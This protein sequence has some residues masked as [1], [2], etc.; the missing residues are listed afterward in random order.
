MTKFLMS[1]IHTFGLQKWVVNTPLHDG[2]S[3]L[4]Q[5]L[6]VKKPPPCRMKIRNFLFSCWGAVSIQTLIRQLLHLRDG[7]RHFCCLYLYI[8]TLD[9]TY[10]MSSVDAQW[11][12]CLNVHSGNVTLYHLVSIDYKSR[13]SLM[14]FVLVSQFYIYLLGV[15]TH[16]AQCL[17]KFLKYESAVIVKLKSWRRFLSS[18]ICHRNMK[19]LYD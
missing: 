6:E 11:H 16:L 10:Y 1:I 3:F 5:E 17:K 7:Q 19:S 18:S 14:I 13:P 12:F 4:Q 15:N 2:T 9:I 8:Q